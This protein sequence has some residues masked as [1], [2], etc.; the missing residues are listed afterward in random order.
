MKIK[1]LGFSL[2]AVLIAY[3]VLVI[4]A[5]D[6]FTLN[7]FLTAAAT[8]GE[9]AKNS[10]Y[11][12]GL[13]S[14]D[15]SFSTRDSRFG[16]QLSADVAS[17]IKLV[18]QLISNGGDADNFNLITDWAFIKYKTTERLDIHV[19]K[20][21]LPFF[22]L[23]DYVSVGYAYP[24]VRPPQEVYAANPLTS[25]TG[26][27]FLVNSSIGDQHL[28]IQFY[29]GSGQHDVF[30]PARAID[31]NPD[32][33]SLGKKKG[34]V[35]ALNTTYMAGATIGLRS[36]AFTVQLGHFETEI[37]VDEFAIEAAEGSV[38]SAGFVLDWKNYVVYSEY[39]L[40]DADS[41][42]VTAL[43]DQE[44]WYVTL[45]YRFGKVLPYITYAEIDVGKDENVLAVQQK[46]AA[47][48]VRYELASN[49][50]LKFEA[51]DAT[52]KANNHGLFDDI[53][54][55]GEVYTLAMDIIF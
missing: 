1:L 4:G 43:A 16:I 41:K 34:D 50:A 32:P 18:S 8:K 49:T 35:V 11:A 5:P 31:L 42:I 3:P 7:G 2:I 55:S 6:N 51:M 27:N 33:G 54:D 36:D 21:K 22:L 30:F 37:E 12:S 48:G 53:V 10:D 52:P 13:A 17:N 39:V 46:S 9:N 28:L 24:W 19:G 40:R 44:A 47:L 26:V 38:S 45:G 25:L 29:Y 15:I 20:F 23:S 14:D